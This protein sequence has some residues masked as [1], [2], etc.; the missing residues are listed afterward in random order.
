M[1]RLDDIDTLTATIYRGQD[2][3]FILTVYEPDGSSA[4]ASGTTFGFTLR[5][6]ENDTATALATLSIGSGITANSSTGEV[7][8]AL[9]DTVTA[10]LT[11]DTTYY[12]QLWRNDSGVKAAIARFEIYVKNRATVI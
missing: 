12:A 3:T 11:A 9:S 2:V 1:I 4:V 7:T 6:A 8:I 10:T 5:A